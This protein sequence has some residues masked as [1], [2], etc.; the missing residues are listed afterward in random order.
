MRKS[1]FILSMTVAMSAMMLGNSAWAAWPN[2]K[3]IE[4]VVGFAPGGG[5]DTMTRTLSRFLE[6]KLGNDARIVVVNKPGAGGELAAT[7]VARS[8]PDGYT[9][10]MVNVPGFIFMPMYRETTYQPEDLALIARLVDDPSLIIA[11]KGSK[12]PADLP[13]II[14]HLKESPGSLS[15]G[16]AGDGTTGHIALLQLEKMKDI[17]AVSIPFKGAGEGKMSLMGQHIDFA[18]ITQSEAPDIESSASDFIGIALASK[19]RKLKSIP[20]TL[21]ENINI[22][23]SSERG[24]GGPKGLPQDINEKLQIA[25]AD[26]MQDPEYLQA[27]KNDVP[28]LSFMPGKEWETHLNNNRKELEPFIPLIKK[29]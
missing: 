21:D 8:K 19:N 1:K 14:K 27:A 24:I 22:F 28:V 23:T 7:Y 29:K 12:V 13:S 11:K 16:H 4:I 9:L 3:P 25:I 5:T 20:T 15:F 26:V 6:K 17:K 2:D 10:G 18:I